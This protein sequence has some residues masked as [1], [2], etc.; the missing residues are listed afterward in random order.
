MPERHL[1]RKFYGES[2]Q[3]SL[4]HL[5]ANIDHFEV[6]VRKDGFEGRTMLGYKLPEWQREEVWTCEQCERFVESVWLGV[7]LGAFMVNESNVSQHDLVLLDGQQR[8]GALR[9]YWKDEFPVIGE[10]GK[11]YYWS[12]MTDKERAHFFRIPF[13]WLLTRYDTEDELKEAYNRHN[14]GGTSHKESE[15]A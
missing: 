1:L 9:R 13:P 14:F 10:D 8:F 6:I 2:M 4:G 3:T 12:D 11:K 7:A 5:F 15:R